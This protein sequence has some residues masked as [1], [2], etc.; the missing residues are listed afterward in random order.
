MFEIVYVW[1]S[2]CRKTNDRMKVFAVKVLS[3]NRTVW[4][5]I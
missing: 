4:I 1:N 5:Q 3:K 2:I